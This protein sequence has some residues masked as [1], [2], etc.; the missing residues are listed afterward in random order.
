M[1]IAELLHS[2]QFLAMQNFEKLLTLYKASFLSHELLAKI[3]INASEQQSSVPIE[4]YSV[5]PKFR[6][7]M[8]LN[9]NFND[10]EITLLLNP[11]NKIIDMDFGL[12]QGTVLSPTASKIEHLTL[13][14]Q[15]YF[16]VKYMLHYVDFKALQLRECYHLSQ[17][18]NTNP[19]FIAGQSYQKSIFN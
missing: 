11:N 5:L 6:N 9:N 12:R 17:Q 4:F 3:T 1:A 19:I 7:N 16:A 14:S 13:K 2:M 15:H 18:V 8:R 10:L